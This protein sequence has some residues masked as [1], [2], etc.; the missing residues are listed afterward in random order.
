MLSLIYCWDRVGSGRL[1]SPELL[2][3]K[4]V[5]FTICGAPL[6]IV[7]SRILHN[8]GMEV[9]RRMQDLAQRLICEWS[10]NEVVKTFKQ[11]GG[12]S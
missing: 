3:R 8:G 10:D 5:G 9:V 11:N 2:Q 7:L 12:V 6:S 1:R 4:D